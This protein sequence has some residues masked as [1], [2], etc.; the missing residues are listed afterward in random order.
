MG[1]EEIVQVTITRETKAVTAAGFGLPLILGLAAVFAER[2]RKYT[3]L[4]GVTDD[5]ATSTDEYKMAQK[6]FGQTPR[7]P[8]ILIGKRTAAVATVVTLTFSGP[9]AAT[10][11]VAGTVN[12]TPV[13]EAFDTDNATTLANIAAAIQADEGVVTAVSNGTNLITITAVT[14]WVLTVGTFTVTGTAPPTVTNATTVTGRTVQDD[15]DDVIDENNDWYGLLLTTTNKGAI[16]AAA[17]RMEAEIKLGFYRSDESGI[18]SPS[19]TTDLAKRLDNAALNRA[20]LMYAQGNITDYPDAAWVGRTFPINPGSSR[21]ALRELAGVT[22]DNLNDTEKSA[23]HDKNANTY[24]EVGGKGITQEG[25]TSGG[26]FID[27]V[28]DIDYLQVR[29][30]EAIFDLFTRVEKIPYTDAGVRTLVGEIE[31][32]LQ[33]RIDDGVVTDFTVTAPKVADVST[34]DKANQLLPDVEFTATYAGGIHK[35]II[36]GLIQV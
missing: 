9:L 36:N 1:V 26:D 33:Q 34:V 30:T 2:A 24:T 4:T 10:H 29:L 32:S 17:N 22:V 14:E 8:S 16:L 7:P 12:T 5:F 27:T 6:L 23:V 13:S 25:K 28:R 11:V 15:I 18:D 35:I 19:S 31:A 20:A 3:N 21:F